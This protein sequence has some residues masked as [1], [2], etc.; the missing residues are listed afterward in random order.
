MKCSRC[1]ANLGEGQEKC[2]RCGREAGGVFQTSAVLI[3]TGESDRVYGSVEEVPPRMRNRLLK[4][5]NGANAAT[6]LIAD[7][8]GRREIARALQNLPGPA[9]RRLI[10][11][12]LG[13]ADAAGRTSW[14]RRALRRALLVLVVLLTLAVFALLYR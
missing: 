14:N 10:R 2:P 9:H 5:T 6:I 8:R 4:S 3:S 13:G 12:I 11:S 1:G 7:R